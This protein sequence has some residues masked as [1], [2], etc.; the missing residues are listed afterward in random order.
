MDSRDGVI[1][2]EGDGDVVE[3]KE[4]RKLVREGGVVVDCVGQC[5]HEGGREAKGS[6][7]SYFS[8]V[9]ARRK[10]RCEGGDF[11]RRPRLRRRI[12]IVRKV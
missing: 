12:P 8:V 6:C 11:T 10:D 5:G 4:L 3:E 9:S 2:L 7:G 1:R